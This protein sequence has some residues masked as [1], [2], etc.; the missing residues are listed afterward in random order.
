M[1]GIQVFVATADNEAS[2]AES[3][4]FEDVAGAEV[5]TDVLG[6]VGMAPME[7]VEVE[8]EEKRKILM[9]TSSGSE[10]VNLT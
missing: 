5:P 9:F 3:P 4:H 6:G 1:L 10:R 2:D 8:E 7:D